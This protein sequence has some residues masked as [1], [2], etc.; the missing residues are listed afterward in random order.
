MYSELLIYI[1]QV[2]LCGQEIHPELC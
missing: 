2:H 1:Y